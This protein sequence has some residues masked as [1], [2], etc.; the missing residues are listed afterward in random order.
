M[1][2]RTKTYLVGEV[3]N[4]LASLPEKGAVGPLTAPVAYVHDLPGGS[5]IAI[6]DPTL[7]R[8]IFE[9]KVVQRKNMAWEKP[10]PS[11]AVLD[12]QGENP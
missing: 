1:N 7:G 6:D 3:R 9:V 11:S 2:E 4:F 8:R 12:D 5:L 10:L